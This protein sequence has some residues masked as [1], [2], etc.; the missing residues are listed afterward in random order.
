MDTDRGPRKTRRRYNTPGDAH[1]L[2]FSCYRKL[3]L[4]NS[5]KTKD[6]LIR[7]IHSARLKHHFHLWAYVIMPDHVHLLIWPVK[8]DYSI[9][10][11]LKTI[12]Q[13]SARQA[14]NYLRKCNPKGLEQLATNQRHDTYRFWQ[15]GGGYD[16]NIS[17]LET[18]RFMVDYIHDNPVRK[19][20]VA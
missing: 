7:A 6:Y 12:K 17:S 19:Q 14:T 1:E 13:S 3:P 10:R 18:L 2:T 8:E 16:R 20:L 11:I 5:D 9:S 15:D 4:L